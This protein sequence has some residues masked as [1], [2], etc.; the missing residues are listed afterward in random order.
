M[1]EVP[2]KV[3]QLLGKIREIVSDDLPNQLPPMRNIQYQMDLV[4]EQV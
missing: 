3:Q 4:L 1:K 2:K